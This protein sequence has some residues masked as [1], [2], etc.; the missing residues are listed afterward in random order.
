MKNKILIL[1]FVIII[2][3]TWAQVTLSDPKISNNSKRVSFFSISL[4]T[5]VISD[6]PLFFLNPLIEYNYSKFGFYIGPIISEKLRLDMY[7]TKNIQSSITISGI[8][9]GC[10]YILFNS[11]CNNKI[12]INL[13]L[14]GGFL[15]YNYS[16]YSEF[17]WGS[18]WIDG[19]FHNTNTTFFLGISPGLS[20]KINNKFFAS[21]QI[22]SGIIY[23][24]HKYNYVSYKRTYNRYSGLFSFQLGINYKFIKLSK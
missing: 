5:C 4:N 21:F 23:N 8:Y 20:F 19:P 7:I 18:N 9:A 16:G 3:D 2:T 1:F 22:G 6:S 10:K 13:F 15:K 14:N 12:S 17:N 24:L 11:L